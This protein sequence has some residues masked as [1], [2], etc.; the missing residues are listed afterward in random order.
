M[1]VVDRTL[2]ITTEGCEWLHEQARPV[3]LSTD[4]R[5]EASLH[6][7]AGGSASRRGEPLASAGG[8][9]YVGHRARLPR[10]QRSRTSK[11][12]IGRPHGCRHPRRLPNAAATQGDSEVRRATAA[13][14]PSTNLTRTSFGSEP[15]FLIGRRGERA[16]F[17]D[18]V[19]C[20]RSG[21]RAGPEDRSRRSRDGP[22]IEPAKMFGAALASPPLAERGAKG[23]SPS[24]ETVPAAVRTVKL[25][26]SYSLAEKSC[27]VRG[28]PS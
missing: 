1:L 5:T 14:P 12:W 17:W 25:S 24:V 23:R 2:W 27:P 18:A 16:Y 28:A 4:G 8:V 11:L 9:L 26:T 6:P 3:R 22:G 7:S 21:S 19:F 20:N 13:H 10:T 15:V